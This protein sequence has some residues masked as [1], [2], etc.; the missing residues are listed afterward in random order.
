ML[1]LSLSAGVF[2]ATSLRALIF[3]AIFALFTVV[4]AKWL[5][6]RIRKNL[7]LQLASALALAGLVVPIGLFGG[8]SLSRVMAIALPLS[9]VFVADTLGVQAILFRARRAP[10]N[11]DRLALL[12][13]VLCATG[14][15]L[16][17]A[18]ISGQAGAALVVG[19][20]L[21]TALA[22]LRPSPRKLKQV[23]VVL[24]CANALSVTLLVL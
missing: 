12:S 11:A 16:C 21:T 1:V 20:F 14:A 3:A 7:P 23:G 8:A 18:L 2:A 4:G 24:G 10:K 17:G 9:L 22:W 5:G 15:V 6:K 19:V 13:V